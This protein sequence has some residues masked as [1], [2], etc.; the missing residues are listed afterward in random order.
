MLKLEKF[1]V[2]QSWRIRELFEAFREEDALVLSTRLVDLI[3]RRSMGVLRVVM[4]SIV[5]EAFIGSPQ[6]ERRLRPR[7]RCVYDGR[8]V[9]VRAR[10]AQEA[11]FEA[12]QVLVSLQAIECGI[13][14]DGRQIVPSYV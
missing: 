12:A 6:I 3:D 1:V 13:V 8:A 14:R 4:F 10:S 5:P 2:K 11:Q 9:V 7:W